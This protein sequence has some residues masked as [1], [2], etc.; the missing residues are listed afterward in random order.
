MKDVISAVIKEYGRHIKKASGKII[1][2]TSRVNRDISIK[3]DRDKISQVISNL[4]GNAIKFTDEGSISISVEKN[5]N[6]VKVTVKDTGS[7]INPKIFPKA[8]FKIF[9]R[10]CWWYWTRTL[11][12]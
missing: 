6:E 5:D 4:V 3:M 11:Y 12:F 8:I 2:L 7:G 1:S 9:F 10:L